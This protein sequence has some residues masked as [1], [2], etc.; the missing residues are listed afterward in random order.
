[1]KIKYIIILI[2][3]TGFMLLFT[4]CGDK[5]QI[6]YNRIGQNLCSC[7][8]DL[9]S[10][11]ERL[12]ELIS[13]KQTEKAMQ[14]MDTLSTLENKLKACIID[15][16]KKEEFLTD[17]KLTQNLPHALDKI[18]ADRTAKILELVKELK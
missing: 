1:M 17:S 15:E 14:L 10:K 6:N 5:R 11:N 2:S 7:S 8:E 18:C 9:K 3:L 16:N 12:T 4:Q 13:K